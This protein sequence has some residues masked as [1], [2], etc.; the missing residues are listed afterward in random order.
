MSTNTHFVSL[1]NSRQHLQDSAQE[2]PSTHSKSETNEMK[3][4]I[5][6]GLHRTFRQD[7]LSSP[8]PLTSP[9]SQNENPLPPSPS[10]WNSIANW[11][12][13]KSN[14]QSLPL[15][16]KK[17]A[18]SPKPLDSTPLLD[19]PSFDSE[20]LQNLQLPAAP[21][22]QMKKWM[23][24]DVSEGLNLMS[25]HSLDAIISIICH[26]Q[27]ELE[28]EHVKVADS[29]FSKYLQFQKTQQTVLQEIKDVL[30]KDA[31]VLN[32][33]KTAQNVAMAAGAIAGIAAAA[34]AAGVLLPVSAF[35]TSAVGVK[36]GDLFLSTATKMGTIGPSVTA[37]LTGLSAGS[38]MYFEHRSNQHR[39]EHEEHQHRDRYYN[40]RTDDTR[41]R[42]AD[43]HGNSG[44]FEELLFK[45][46]KR[47]NILRKIVLKR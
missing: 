7:Q 47:L 30:V 8:S 35:I 16:E 12:R 20:D 5:G 26:M 4:A 34:A 27:L 22:K 40:A 29:T 25:Q 31:G 2:I 46:L 10:F 45:Q 14:Q 9:T 17:R 11:W 15:N 36:A 21:T 6:Y 41:N 28:K 3:I 38:K 23:P 37:G 32:Y 39:A 24:S 1:T 13:G 19:A 18:P 42:L 43:I 33:F 44:A